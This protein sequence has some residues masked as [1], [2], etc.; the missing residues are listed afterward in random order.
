MALFP[1]ALVLALGVAAAGGQ[2]ACSDSSSTGSGRDLAVGDAS[3]SADG[4]HF[5]F[6]EVDPSCAEVKAMAKLNKVDLLFLLD[7]SGSMG[8]GVNGDPTQKWNPVTATLKQFFADPKSKGL[9]ASLEFFPADGNDICNSST[10]YFPATSLTALPDSGF[11]TSIDATTPM[12]ETPTLP[13]IIGTIDYGVDSLATTPSDRTAIV[14][15]TDGLPAGCE[16]SVTNVST[17]CAKVR[18]AHDINTYVIGVGDN[19]SGLTKIAEEGGTTAPVILSV[20]DPAKTS[21]DFLTALESVRGSTL[22]CAFDIPAL[23][24]SNGAIDFEKVNVQYT[25]A[26]GSATAV[27]RSPDCAFAS[28]WRYDDPTAPKRVELCSD[29]CNQVRNDEMGKMEIIFGCATIIF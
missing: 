21:A 3:G 28:G 15:V 22:S 5:D 11:A 27:P 13:A 18:L 19:L 12:G 9:R 29:L 7:R 20:G 26:G 23:D 16:S 24:P 17:E 25:P 4:H 14:L 6:G 8:D 2:V 10:Y 1:R